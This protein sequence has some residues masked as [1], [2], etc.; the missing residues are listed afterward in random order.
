MPSKIQISSENME[1]YNLTGDIDY[2]LECM[3]AKY[4]QICMRVCY[5]MLVKKVT[6]K[7]YI[8]SE[9]YRFCVCYYWT[10]DFVEKGR[11][12]VRD[13]LFSESVHY[14]FLKLPRKIGSVYP[15]K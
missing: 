7:T 12:S 5:V 14:V 10:P 11:P 15:E 13:A 3:C 9:K 8:Y 6:D 1:I 4:R 2:S